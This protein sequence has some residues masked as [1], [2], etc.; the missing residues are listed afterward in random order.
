VRDVATRRD[1]PDELASLKYYPPAFTKD[2]KGLYYS[3]FP[4]PAPGKEISATDHDC[5][6]YFHAIG[7]PASADPI[8]YERPDHPSW[9]FRPRITEDGRYLVIEIGDGEVGDRGQ[10]QLVYLDLA[11]PHPKPAALIDT[12]DAEYL[13]LGSRGPVFYVQTTL[14]APKKRIVAIDTRAPARAKWKEIV[15]AG[16]NAIDAAYLVGKQILVTELRDAHTAVVAYDLDGKKIRDLALPG[17]GTAYGF[18]GRAGD[19]DTYYAYESL[20]SPGVVHRYDLATGA[21]TPWRAPK[22]AFDPGALET[23][24]V[25]YPSKDGT[26]IPMF[27]TARKGT[28][29]DGTSPTLLTGYGGFG[30]SMTPYFDP[31]HIAWIERGGT[32]A[33]AN[34]RGGGEYGE[35]W[36]QVA[37]RTHRQIVYDDFLAAAGWLVAERVT[38]RERL[39]SFGTSGGGLLVAAVLMQRPDLFGAVAPIAGVHDMIRFPLFGEGAGWQGEM[40]SPDDPAELRALLATSPL[41]NVRPAARYP[42]TLVVTGDHDVRVTPLH[43]YKLAA[44]MQAAQAAPAPVLLRVRTTA[45]HGGATRKSAHL[46]DDAELLAFFAR[47][48]GMAP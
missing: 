10:E 6:V 36:H 26:K 31:K 28:P 37:M 35:A 43:S 3:R 15:K 9:Q 1:L 41:H 13:F 23:T 20:S 40:G 4:A 12:F 44:A 18:G 24:Q 30:A 45:G 2:G 47:Y 8:V 33:M 48:L 42:A 19:A 34:L 16:D 32:L 38:S 7:T 11:D 21:S 5:K 14:D 29:R 39:G 25:F 27:L 46:D 17:L 22:L